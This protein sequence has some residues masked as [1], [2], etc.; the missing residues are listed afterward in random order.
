MKKLLL[1]IIMLLFIPFNCFA[2][3]K[4]KI[5]EIILKGPDSVK[6]GATF[7]VEVSGSYSGFNRTEFGVQGIYLA[8]V[9]F[10]FDEDV[11]ILSDY[12][13]EGYNSTVVMQDDLVYLF[14]EVND[15][16]T[17]KCADGFFNCGPYTAKLTFYVKDVDEENTTI[18][19]H[20]LEFGVFDVLDEDDFDFDDMDDVTCERSKSIKVKINDSVVTSSPPKSVIS[21]SLPS[22]GESV[23]KKDNVL[24]PD[25]TSEDKKEA[26]FLKSLKIKN[27]SLNFK[28][29]V[30]SYKLTLSDSVN[31]LK[32]D[33]EAYD[34]DTEI[35]IVGAD[36]LKDASDIVKIKLTLPSGEKKTYT[37]N[38]KR[39]SISDSESASIIHK[40]NYFVYGVLGFTAFVVIIGLISKSRDKRKLKKLLEAQENE[41]II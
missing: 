4:I 15:L 13:A 9:L 20:S 16:K 11:L 36:N 27:Y 35:K 38:I 7:T 30:T 24:A 25:E 22:I 33:A 28:E 10:E 19:I 40:L 39:E 12:S 8:G 6:K 34:K 3:E 23:Q 18:K 21:D 5:N 29:D 26:K 37:I 17:N 41:T 32:I 1:I 2:A 31:K 14:G